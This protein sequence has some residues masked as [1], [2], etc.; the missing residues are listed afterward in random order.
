VISGDA[1][2]PILAVF[3]SRMR[4]RKLTPIGESDSD[5]SNGRPGGS[6][7]V[8]SIEGRERVRWGAWEVSVR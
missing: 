8:I 3:L 2:A 7:L 1:N 6:G 4:R 5:D